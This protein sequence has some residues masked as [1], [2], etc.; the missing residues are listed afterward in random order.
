[1]RLCFQFETGI[2]VPLTRKPGSGL[3]HEARGI[4]SVAKLE[5]YLRCARRAFCN[6]AQVCQAFA[7]DCRDGRRCVAVHLREIIDRPVAAIAEFVRFGR[8]LAT[9][10]NR[11]SL[12]LNWDLAIGGY[13][14]IKNNPGKRFDSW[15]QA[16][17]SLRKA[18]EESGVL[19][20]T[21]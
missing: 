12:P 19:K 17:D 7:K 2:K 10:Q 1:M 20:T 16:P 4:R 21:R 5:S 18:D 8:E 9:P 13:L 15:L 11:R 14:L 3:S 6:R